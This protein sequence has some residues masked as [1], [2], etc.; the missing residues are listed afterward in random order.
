ML[1]KEQ[2]DCYLQAFYLETFY[3]ELNVTPV[4]VFFLE[5]MKI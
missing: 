3:R 2:S 1:C 4:F 5:N